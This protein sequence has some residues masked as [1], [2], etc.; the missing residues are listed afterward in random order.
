MTTPPPCSTPRCIAISLSSEDT[1]L[2]SGKSYYFTLSATNKA[3]LTS[4]LTSDP[5]LYTS[6]TPTPGVVLDFD[7]EASVEIVSGSSYHLS[8]IDV[9]LEGSEFGVLWAGFSHPTAQINYSVG[10]GQAPGQDD[11][12]PFT[13]VG[14]GVSSHV[15]R[16]VSLLEGFTYYATV[17]A[18][19]GF[20]RSSSSSN[21]VLVLRE[22]GQS[23]QLASVYDSPTGDVEYQASSS[24]VSAQWFF[25]TSFHA[26]ISH[27]MWGVVASDGA[28]GSGSGNVAITDQASGPASGGVSPELL[29]VNYQHV[30]KA[31]TGVTAV[32]DGVLRA[33]GTVYRNVVRACFATRCLPPVYSDGFRI[34][35]LPTP[36]GLNATYTPLQPDVVYGTSALGQLDLE[37][38]EFGDPQLAYYEWSLGTNEEG[39]ELL[40]DWQQVEWFER[41]VS[42]LFNVTLSLHYPNIVTLRGYNSAGLYAD[43]HTSLLWNIGGTVL[44]QGSVPLDP[45]VVYDLPQSYDD[46][47]VTGWEELVYRDITLQDI[48]YIAST[49]SLSGGWPN[50]R[51]TQYRY[52]ISSLQQYLP[53]GTEGSLGCGNTFH[54]SATVPNLPLTEG[55]KYY[56]CVQAL[57]ENAIHRTPTTPPVLEVCSN[58]VIVDTSPPQ[59]GCVKII[60]NLAHNMD[61]PGSGMGSG[62]R[63][64]LRPLQDRRCTTVNNTRFQV[65]TSD[66][67]LIWDDFVDVELY[68]NT[69]HAS[70][71]ASYGYAL[72]GLWVP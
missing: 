41:Q 48:D 35:Q 27:Y 11:I 16:E 71:V 66:L 8:D 46:Q 65:S 21:G 34:A 47:E 38:E 63:E 43:T 51:Y 69:I 19:T 56:F 18:D 1:P 14:G 33:D 20:S 58:G 55:S 9:L 28:S 61:V 70:G 2:S 24:H 5:Y 39:A 12:I 37:W 15:F 52:S 54:N 72:G 25:P 53:C 3:G 31:V 17:V 7:P 4:F 40:V 64:T 23:L 67:Y 45:L 59:G 44:D 68:G 22:W 57:A 36:G 32:S 60:P 30:G 6:A 62:F 29:A 42:V 26:R 13:H 10:L 49:S 50:L